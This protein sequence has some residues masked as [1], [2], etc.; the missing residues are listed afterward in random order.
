VGRLPLHMHGIAASRGSKRYQVNSRGKGHASLLTLQAAKR[1]R[2]I[3]V[4]V[5]GLDPISSS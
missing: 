5:R 4:V 3:Q 1:S 2:I